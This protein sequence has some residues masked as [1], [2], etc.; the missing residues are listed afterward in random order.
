MFKFISI[1]SKTS[2]PRKFI[3]EKYEHFWRP[4]KFIPAKY[5]NFLGS[6]N[7]ESFFR[8]RIVSSFKVYL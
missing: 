2:Y 6:P 7:C 8:N 4:R 1:I 3:T 5:K